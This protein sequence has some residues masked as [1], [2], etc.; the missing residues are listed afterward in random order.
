M[1]D[2]VRRALRRYVTVYGLTEYIKGMPYPYR[3]VVERLE[4]HPDVRPPSVRE[5]IGI[6][7]ELTGGLPA[8]TYIRSLRDANS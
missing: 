2:E 8:E 5:L 4:L 6:A 3:I 1:L 7:P